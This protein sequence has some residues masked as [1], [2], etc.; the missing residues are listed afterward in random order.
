MTLSY[1]LRHLPIYVFDEEGGHYDNDNYDLPG[2]YMWPNGNIYSWNVTTID[3]LGSLTPGASVLDLFWEKDAE[4]E[5]VPVATA[6]EAET[7]SEKSLTEPAVDLHRLHPLVSTEP[8]IT[9]TERAFLRTI[10]IITENA[11][12]L[13]LG[14][15]E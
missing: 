8:S 5:P 9:M 2:I 7:E 15:V 4:E 10:A 6:P 12:N 3:Y 1:T 14:E 11:D 13:K